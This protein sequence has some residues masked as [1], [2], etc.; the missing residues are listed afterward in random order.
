M[1]KTDLR[2]YIQFFDDVFPPDACEA[3]VERFEAH[4]DPQPFRNDVFSF[5]QVNCNTTPGFGDIAQAVAQAAAH[6]ADEYFD[7]LGLSL[8]PEI[9]GFEHVRLKRYAVG[10]DEFREHVDVAD[11][12]SARRFLVCMV[13]LRDNE[14][15]ETV[16]RGLDKR[17]ACRQGSME[18][19]PPLWLFPHA[20][21]PPVKVPKYT[22]CTLL[23]Y[24]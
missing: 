15:G 20:G 6:Y 22:V 10:R 4:A 3:M 21:L 1:Q 7:S 16:F 11:Y 5:D 8:R 13:Y 14:G 12:A 17:I 9:Q 19:F 23:H 18:V 24:L 2:D